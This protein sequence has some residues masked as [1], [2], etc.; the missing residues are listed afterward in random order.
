ML[1]ESSETQQG[2]ALHRR[3]FSDNDFDLIVWQDPSGTITAFQLCYDK[4][5]HE[6]A[7]NWSAHEGFTHHAVDT[8]DRVMRLKESPTLTP[9]MVPPDPTVLLSFEA[10]SQHVEPGIRSFV[11]HRLEEF[12]H[13]KGDS[14][15]RGWS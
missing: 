14:S 13:G 15:T 2:E 5:T 4:R 11:I 6:R 9:T 7:I 1:R 8:G 12:L 10:E 3:W